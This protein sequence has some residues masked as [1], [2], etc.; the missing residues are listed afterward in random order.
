MTT[1]H[2]TLPR[3]ELP[4]PWIDSTKTVAVGLLMALGIHTFVAEL[5]YIPSESMQPTL[6]VGDRL[7]VEKLSY[8]FHPPQR[9]DLV[10]FKAPP[11]LEAQNLHDDLIKRVVGLPGD[12]VQ[13]RNGQTLINGKVI[14]EPYVKEE[15]TYNY[16]PVT[17]PHRQYFVLGDNRNHS[18][19]SHIWGS[20]PKQNIIGRAVLQIYPLTHFRV[21]LEH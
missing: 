8:R 19:D 16:G 9:N 5:R 1:L 3:K 14:A 6:E 11:E 20:V 7:L 17:V 18:Y 12:V 13:I 15:A 21:L 10:V 2:S 4:N